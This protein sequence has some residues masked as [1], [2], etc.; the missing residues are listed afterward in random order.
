MR[1]RMRA[2]PRS[3]KKAPKPDGPSLIVV[4]SVSAMAV[5]GYIVGELA[6]APKPH[7]FHWS[8]ALIGALLGWA[9]GRVYF[10]IKGDII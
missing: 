2:G 4:L 3:Q 6:L 10:N 8:I 1:K 5:V 9:G 7:P